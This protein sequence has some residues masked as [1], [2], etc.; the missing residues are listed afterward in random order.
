MSVETVSDPMTVKARKQHRCSW[1][2]KKIAKGELHTA[3]TLKGDEIYTW[4]ECGRCREYVSEMFETHYYWD[5]SDGV[6]RD[7]FIEFMRENHPDVL[8]EWRQHDEY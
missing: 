6:T 2:G 7:Q 3:S 4:R 1:C 5:A 8:R